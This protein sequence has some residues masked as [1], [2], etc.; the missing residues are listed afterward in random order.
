MSGGC[1]SLARREDSDGRRTRNRRGMGV[2]CGGLL[3]KVVGILIYAFSHNHGSV[4]Y[5][6]I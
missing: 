4:E 2:M 6:H 1:F 3:E 5:G